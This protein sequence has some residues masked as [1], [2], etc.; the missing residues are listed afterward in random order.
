MSTAAGSGP[1]AV[2]QS[3][4]CPPVRS[5]ASGCC[6]PVSSHGLSA[7]RWETRELQEATLAR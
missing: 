7:L 5:T 4:R 2:A 3:P 6:H 1:G